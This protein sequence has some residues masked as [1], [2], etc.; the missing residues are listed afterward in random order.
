MDGLEQDTLDPCS[1]LPEMSEPP[2]SFRECQCQCRA[3]L[4]E[5][6]MFVCLLPL[7]GFDLSCVSVQETMNFELRPLFFLLEIL[8]S[9]F[10]LTIHGRFRQSPINFHHGKVRINR[11]FSLRTPFGLLRPPADPAAGSPRR[12]TSLSPVQTTGSR[13]RRSLR[14]EGTTMRRKQGPFADE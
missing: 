8:F 3:V 2:S 1:P 7:Q 6:A 11:S 9:D 14:T 13:P 5:N 12:A 4:F 10:L